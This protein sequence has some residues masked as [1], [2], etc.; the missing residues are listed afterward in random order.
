MRILFIGN[1]SGTIV[2]FRKRLIEKFISKN[3]DVYTLTMDNNAENFKQIIN[4]GAHPS[5][6]EFSRSG[7]NP[8]S[9]IY[10]TFKLSKIIKEL[11]PDVVFC[12]FPKPVIF[13]A[14]ASRLAGIKKID[15]LL[16]GL[17]YCYTKHATPDSFKKKVL[18]TVQTTL[19]RIV[20]P[21]CRQVMFL[22]PDDHKELLINN[23]ITVKSTQVV[24]G[25]GVNLNEYNYYSPKIEPVHFTM[26]SRLL[27]EKGVRE[28][29]HAAEK[30]KK[31]YPNVKFSIAGTFDDNPGGITS[32]EF[33][34][35]VKS[36][37]VEFLGQISDIKSHLENCSVFVL[38][39][40]REGVPRSTQ[41]A[42]AVGRPIITTD[43]PGCRETV[44]DGKNGFLIP[45]WNED[46]LADKMMTFIQQPELIVT[47]GKASREIA[48][49]KFDEE[50]ACDLLVSVILS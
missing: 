15:V 21:R 50:Q 34:S 40:Y 49:A 19:Y 39:S 35:W 33:E 44:I 5:R 43:V 16:E 29:V 2:L 18:R 13:G 22:N 23:N 26:V 47:M 8:L 25:I 7:T 3:C 46:A 1:Q 6:Y 30:V 20:L 9:D 28:F 41:E 14:L 10:N 37:D 42:M 11:K 17:G 27:I 45:P 31:V 36:G 4:I 38:P 12:F 24:G 32:A 48:Q